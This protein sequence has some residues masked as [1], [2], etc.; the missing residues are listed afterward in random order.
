MNHYIYDAGLSSLKLSLSIRPVVSVAPPQ[1]LKQQAH[2]VE[3]N[4]SHSLRQILL[5]SNES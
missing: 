1:V 2:V 4:P 5:A 3:T